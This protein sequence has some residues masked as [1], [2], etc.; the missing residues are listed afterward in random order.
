MC[1]LGMEFV[2]YGKAIW[3]LRDITLAQ[4]HTNI[5]HSHIL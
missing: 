4:E 1:F 5:A 2:S 3:A